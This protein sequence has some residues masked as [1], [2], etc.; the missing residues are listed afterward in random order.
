[1]EIRIAYHQSSETLMNRISDLLKENGITS[2]LNSAP[3][4][5]NGDVRITFVKEKQNVMA[6]S[7]LN[8]SFVHTD[9]QPGY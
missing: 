9:A 2:Q 1:M 5:S 4:A 6:T 7:L 8:S 3:S